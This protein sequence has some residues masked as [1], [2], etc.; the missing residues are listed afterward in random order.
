MGYFANLYVVEAEAT[1]TTVQLR[2]LIYG[3]DIGPN[4]YFCWGPG[5]RPSGLH[6]YAGGTVLCDAQ[7][8]LLPAYPLIETCE[9]LDRCL[10]EATF[11]PRH[12]DDPVLFHFVL[13]KGFIPRRDMKPLDQPIR[14]FIDSVD[15]RIIVTYPVIGPATIRFWVTRLEKH[16]SIGDYEPHKL[17]HPDEERPPKIGFEFNLGVFKLKYG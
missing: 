11:R 1:G 14:P 12:D 4:A 17:L 5:E 16:E 6:P 8:R 15:E 13:P 2:T 9:D 7:L 10:L 3:K